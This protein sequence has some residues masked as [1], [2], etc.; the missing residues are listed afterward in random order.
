MAKSILL[1]IGAATLASA[2][3]LDYCLV[4]NDVISAVKVYTSA[5]P[6]CSSFLQIPTVTRY[7]I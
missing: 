2:A 7:D 4:V 6:F 3:T 1:L 5:T